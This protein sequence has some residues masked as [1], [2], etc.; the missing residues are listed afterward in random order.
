MNQSGPKNRAVTRWKEQEFVGEYLKQLDKALKQAAEERPSFETLERNWRQ[1]AHAAGFSPHDIEESWIWLRLALVNAKRG[2]ARETPPESVRRV[3]EYNALHI[4]GYARD[5][6]PD[7]LKDVGLTYDPPGGDVEDDWRQSAQETGLSPEEI[8]ESWAWLRR[9]AFEAPPVLEEAEQRV[10]RETMPNSVR[11]VLIRHPLFWF[12]GQD[13]DLLDDFGLEDEVQLEAEADEWR[14]W[15]NIGHAFTDPRD[16]DAR[17]ALDRLARLVRLKPEHTRDLARQNGISM[18]AMKRRLIQQA[19]LL[20][21]GAAEERIRIGQRKVK[22]DPGHPIT[23]EDVFGREG[24]QEILSQEV[25]R[26]L[27]ETNQE[28]TADVRDKLRRSLSGQ[29]RPAYV[30]DRVI[31]RNWLTKEIRRRT[32]ELLAQDLD[33]A[34]AG[35]QGGSR[36][37]EISYDETEPLADVAEGELAAQSKALSDNQNIRAAGKREDREKAHFRT[38]DYYAKRLWAWEKKSRIEDAI[39]R[40]V[41][42]HLA[43][44]RVLR[45]HERPVLRRYIECVLEDPQLMSDDVAAAGQLGWSQGKVRDVKRRLNRYIA[46][47]AASKHSKLLRPRAL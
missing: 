40:R 7:L 6:A 18:E 2:A 8:E 20:S 32:E 5:L 25:L 33:I 10:A 35:R 9:H 44:E 30:T 34:E 36:R 4:V 14:F 37:K 46:Q 24:L 16:A 47:S 29:F 39:L 31:Y 15:D 3:I 13:R 12:V 19:V 1:D 11:R 45:E 17:K 43:V 26:N 42:W 28:P 22:D 38:T 27:A 41:D 21:L 23:L